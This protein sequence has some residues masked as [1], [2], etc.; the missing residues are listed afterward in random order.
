MH[1]DQITLWL[2]LQEDFGIEVCAV[3]LTATDAALRHKFAGRR[4]F[5]VAL[6]NSWG[7]GCPERDNGL[8]FLLIKDQRALESITG[9]LQA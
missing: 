4:E 6:F 1:T 9:I 8:M 7:V 3:T 5:G 2:Q